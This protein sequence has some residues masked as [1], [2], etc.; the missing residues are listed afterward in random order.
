MK[1]PAGATGHWILAGP[2]TKVSPLRPPPWTMQAG[3]KLRHQ[4]SRGPSP[5]TFH[6]F[7]TRPRAVPGILRIK[8]QSRLVNYNFFPL[9]GAG[10]GI[11]RIPHPTRQAWGGALG[12]KP[13]LSRPRLWVVKAEDRRSR[14]DLRA[15]GG[16]CH[17]RKKGLGLLSQG[18]FRHHH[19][20]VFQN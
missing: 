9:R 18:G 10:Q 7:P 6:D 5:T 14:T 4:P 17:W 2:T 13:A 12:R 16:R 15:N 1:P 8:G 20:G 3:E 19:Q 11:G